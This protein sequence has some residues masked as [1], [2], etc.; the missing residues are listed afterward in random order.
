M[1]NKGVTYPQSAPESLQTPRSPTKAETDELRMMI[2][3]SCGYCGLL[4][5]TRFTTI[6]GR[7]VKLHKQLDHWKPKSKGGELSDL[8]VACHVCNLWKSNRL[9]DTIEEAKKYL[10]QKWLG[11][12]NKD[13]ISPLM[14]HEDVPNAPLQQP[15][16]AKT[17]EEAIRRNYLPE[18]P[19]RETND[20]TRSEVLLSELSSPSIQG[21][22]E[23]ETIR[24]S[25]TKPRP[26]SVVKSIV[27]TEKD[28]SD[29]L[30]RVGSF[31]KDYPLEKLLPYKD[32]YES[33]TPN[34][35]EC[36][37]RIRIE[38]IQQRRLNETCS[39]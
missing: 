29:V 16:K 13:F 31:I 36:L 10:Q 2:H 22:E 28:I 8:I 18:L 21:E 39:T 26:K 7:S 15:K 20:E 30:E 23:T 24:K 4:L 14:K 34:E 3:E 27:L 19:R 6:D 32:L 37:V 1:R 11:A 35:V 25:E 5:G 38:S 17:Y 9:F 33:F 12:G